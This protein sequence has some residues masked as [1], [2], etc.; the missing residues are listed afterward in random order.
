MVTFWLTKSVNSPESQDDQI[1]IRYDAN[2][3]LFQVD[4]VDKQAGGKAT[5]YNK[6]EGQTR[7]RTM[8]Y[9]RLLLKSLILDQDGYERVQVDVPGLPQFL[10][11]VASLRDLY[12]REHIEDMVELGLDLMWDGLQIKKETK[13]PHRRVSSASTIPVE[14]APRPLRVHLFFDDEE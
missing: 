4:M 9:V 13:G 6:V 8:R 5:W 11:R 7:G 3:D 14:E 10:T 2:L 1:R 12:V